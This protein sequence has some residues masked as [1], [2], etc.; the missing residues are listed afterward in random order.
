[1][2]AKIIGTGRNL[3]ENIITNDDLSAIVDT[4]DEWISS[5][6][7][8]RERRLVK[9]ESTTSMAVEASKHAIVKANI[10]P[11]EIDLIIVATISADANMPS[12]ACEVQAQ[13]GAE[14][15]V[16]FD[17]IAACSGF[18][19][20]LNTAYAYFQTGM[21]KRALIIGSETLSKLIDWTDRRTC[22]L[23]GDGAGAVVVEASEVGIYEMVQ[24]TD[25]SKGNVLTCKRSTTSNMLIQTESQME[26]IAM[27]GQE[28]LRFAVKKVPE[29][30]YAVLEKARLSIE[31]ITYFVLH[32]ANER[33]I[34]SV[35]KKLK[36]PIEKFPLNIDQ[37]GNTSSASIPI[38]LDEMN[39]KNKL[40]KGDKI[41]LSGFGGGLSWGATIVEW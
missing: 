9:N 10:S 37:Y 14:N 3:P 26:Y 27:D 4:N 12:T 24:Y 22:V 29:S 25:G 38:L 11:L 20:A 15:A 35:A 23:F 40:H 28:V 39:E 17:M 33:I 2:K 30:I 21:Y 6:T 1:M 18:I 34:Q 7:G 13:L 8:I 16:A 36:V 41:L 19:F 32:Q 31:T 5:R